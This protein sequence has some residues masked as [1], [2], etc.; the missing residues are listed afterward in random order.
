[1]ELFVKF[2]K[3]YLNYLISIILPAIISGVS[4]PLFKHLLGSEG[5]GKF[6][7]WFNGILIISAVLTGWISQSILRFFAASNNK[8]NLSNRGLR[9]SAKTQTIFL[10]PVLLTAWLIGK[11]VTLAILCVFAMFS[12]S[13]Q[14]TVLP[15]IQSSFLS[16]KI[17]YS[18]LIRILI[19]VGGGYL[20]LALTNLFYIYSLLIAA[21]ISYSSAF[22]YLKLNIKK[23]VDSPV[24][25]SQ[26]LFNNDI[27]IKRFYQ[28]GI[29][30]SAWFIFSY[31]LTY[32]DKLFT[33]HFFGAQIQGNYQAV[34]DLI[35]KSLSLIISPVITSVFPLLSKAYETEDRSHIRSLIKKILF[36]EIFAFAVVSIGYWSIGARVLFFILNTP[37]LSFYK[38]MGF[39]IICATFIWQFN[40]LI[41]K[42][43]ELRL[44]TGLLLIMVSVSFLSQFFFYFIFRNS[45]NELIAPLGY[46][47][48]AVVYLILLVVPE[49]NLLIRKIKNS[50]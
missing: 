38:W 13:M 19:Y 47:V 24:I 43:F 8:F 5:Y 27:I 1:M 17:I 28:Y 49:L 34:F 32:I 29:P 31:L 45:S 26:N 48:S 46:L 36:Y 35:N 4:I 39:I 41:Q 37:Y 18:E 22:I 20:L 7:L 25:G 30:L 3:D 33:F 11:D 9:L 15:I 44:R 21:I 10:L 40:I 12:I 50:N 42:R 14:F 6:A 2:K 16:R 23:E